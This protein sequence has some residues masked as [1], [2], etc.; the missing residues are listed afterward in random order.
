MAEDEMVGQHPLLNEHE[1]EQTLGDI[2]GWGSLA[3]CST[4]GCKELG[5]T[6][7]LNDNQDYKRIVSNIIIIY[8]KVQRKQKNVEFQKIGRFIIYKYIW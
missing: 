6:Q 2:E 8:R 4:W 7:Q 5:T 1:F 3:C